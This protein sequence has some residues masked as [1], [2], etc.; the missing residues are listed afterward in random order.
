MK[1][2]IFVAFIVLVISAVVVYNQVSDY[3]WKRKSSEDTTPPPDTPLPVEVDLRVGQST[4]VVAGGRTIRL[5]VSLASP[6]GHAGSTEDLVVAW[7]ERGYKR[8]SLRFSSTEG[9]PTFIGPLAIRLL[10]VKAEPDTIRPGRTQY[11]ATLEIDSRA[12]PDSTSEPVEETSPE[13]TG[14]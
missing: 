14:S 13:S 2:R 6:K 1:L 4:A 10:D 7:V 3:Q 11:L 8:H 5:G 9:S 12:S